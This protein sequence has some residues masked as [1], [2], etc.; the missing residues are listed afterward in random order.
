ME[1]VTW[2]A[3][4]KTRLPNVAGGVEGWRAEV[5]TPV[6]ATSSALAER[7]LVARQNQIAAFFSGAAVRPSAVSAPPVVSTLG[8]D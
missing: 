8:P 6:Q 3:V 4:L 2:D 1:E 7:E 5:L